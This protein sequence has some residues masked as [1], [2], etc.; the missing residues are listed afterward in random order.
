MICRPTNEAWLMTR[1]AQVLCGICLEEGS[2]K[3][4]CLSLTHTPLLYAMPLKGA[5]VIKYRVVC[6]PQPNLVVWHVPKRSSHNKLW[7]LVIKCNVVCPRPSLL[8]ECAMRCL[9]NTIDASLFHCAHPLPFIPCWEEEN[10]PKSE[11]KK[12]CGSVC[13]HLSSP[14]L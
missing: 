6:P 10:D 11:D 13:H 1:Y 9:Q 2:H 4:G 12:G 7:T 14:S 8:C 5:F 3:N